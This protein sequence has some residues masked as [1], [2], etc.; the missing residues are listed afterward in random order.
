MSQVSPESFAPGARLA[1][2]R[3]LLKRKIEAGF[4]GELWLGWD[5][6]LEMDVALHLLPQHLARDSN[7]VELLKEKAEAHLQLSHPNIVRTLGF[8]QDQNAAGVAM[9]HV[10]GWSLAALKV[11]R[12]QR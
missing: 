1:G 6:T 8:V 5:R 10:A 12:P 4:L 9:D 3:Y 11:D 2:G 7:L